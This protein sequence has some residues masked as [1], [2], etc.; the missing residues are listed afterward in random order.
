MV[1]FSALLSLLYFLFYIG[2]LIIL[3]AYIYAGLSQLFRRL[4]SYCLFLLLV[5]LVCFAPGN[6]AGF[7]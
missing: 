3:F 4:R 6:W 1:E 5:I 2:C 7:I